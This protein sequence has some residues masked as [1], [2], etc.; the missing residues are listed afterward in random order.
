MRRGDMAHILTFHQY[1]LL[2][3][4]SQRSQWRLKDIAQMLQVS[5][6][7]VCK[8][9]KRLEKQGVIQ[10]E[11]GTVDP[12]CMSIRLTQDGKEAIQFMS[13]LQFL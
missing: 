13:R 11:M 6:S 10:K 4:L 5:K 9:V 7:A 2:E 8:C 1:K 12:Q 3:L